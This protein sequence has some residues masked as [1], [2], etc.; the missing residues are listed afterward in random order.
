M[1]SPARWRLRSTRG[2]LRERAVVPLARARDLERHQV[3]EAAGRIAAQDLRGRHA[4]ARKVVLRQVDAPA[5]RVLADVAHDVGQLEGDAQVVRVAGRR[6]DR[7]SRRSAPTAAD[8]AGDPVAIGEQRVEVRVA[9]RDRGPSACRRSLPAARLRQR[10]LDDDRRQRQ[11]ATGCCALAGVDRA[12]PR[13]ATTRASAARRRGRG[14][15][16]TTSSTSRQNA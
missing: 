12:R 11:R 15:S 5:A 2:K 4:K 13:R 1:T 7:R 3:A 8:D 16:S 9:R 10:V 14:P 6:R